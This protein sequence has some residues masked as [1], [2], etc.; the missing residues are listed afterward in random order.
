[1]SNIFI[2]IILIIIFVLFLVFSINNK[3]RR[4]NIIE[5]YL[6]ANPNLYIFNI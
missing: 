6:K 5:N 1:M 4:M 2:N 3:L